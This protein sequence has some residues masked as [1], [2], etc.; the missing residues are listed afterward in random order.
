MRMCQAFANHGHEVVLFVP[1]SRKIEKSIDNVFHYYGVDPIFKIRKMPRWSFKGSGRF[2]NLMSA[3]QA[4][5]LNPDIVYSRNVVGC[6]NCLKLGLPSIFEAHHPPED[7]GQRNLKRILDMPNYK[8]FKAL[9]VITNALKTYYSTN[10]RQFHRHIYVAPDG[11]EPVPVQTC[12]RSVQLPNNIGSRMK[13]GY[14]GHL[15]KGRGIEIIIDL[16]ERCDWAD[17]HIF[18]GRQED[19]E[20]WNNILVE[21]KNIFLHGFVYPSEVIQYRN[22]LH[23]LLAPYQ[24]KVFVSSG[25]SETS[26]WMSPLKIFEYMSFCKPIICSDLPVLRE[27]L[28]H[29]KNALL[30]SPDDVQS[31]ERSLIRLRDD[32]NLM[33]VLGG[34]AYEDFMKHYTWSARANNL[35][36]LMS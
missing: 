17:F 4:K 27:V 13:V 7:Y 5:R 19:I 15:Y 28:E 20:Y 30:C 35:I 11:A 18:G 12:L 6:Y 22:S 32:A 25:R 29:E 14:F 36:S 31:W 26:K 10:Y 8:C 3:F 2:F 23:V 16:A 24:K 1:N 34:Q 33:Q 9:V 21:R